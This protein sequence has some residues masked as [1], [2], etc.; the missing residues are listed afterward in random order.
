MNYILK[1]HDLTKRYGTT[2]AVDRVNMTI[3]RGDIYGCI[4]ENGAGKSTIIRLIT[5]LA[6]PT[7]GSFELFKKNRL[8]AIAAVVESPSLHLSLTAEQNMHYQCRMLGLDNYQERTREILNVVGLHYLIGHK[9]AAKNFSLG[10]KQR[11]GIAMALISNPEFIILDE[12][13]NGLDPVGIIEMREL[14]KKLN[15]ERGITF[16]ISSHILSEL[17]KVATKYG[18]L[19]H[20]KLLKEVSVEE[21]YETSRASVKITFGNPV[22]SEIKEILVGYDYEIIQ[23]NIVEIK[24]NIE[25]HKLLKAF[26]K[27]DIIVTNVENLNKTIEDYYLEI[28]GGKGNA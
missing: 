5:G 16:F 6:N 17:D 20:G 11:L 15:E 19:S 26:V 21:L 3:E 4:G 12:P 22:G 9:K 27:E 28:I 10:M 23:A 2:L 8:G 13:M 1:T 24:G 14:I 25:I 7:S 18:F